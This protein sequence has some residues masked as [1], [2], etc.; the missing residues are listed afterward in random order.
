[1]SPC[2]VVEDWK[3]IMNLSFRITIC[4]FFVDECDHSSERLDWVSVTAQR[5]V[6]LCSEKERSL[7]WWP[8]LL[9]TDSEQMEDH[10]PSYLY[11]FL[12]NLPYR[13]RLGDGPINFNIFGWFELFFEVA[14]L[15]RLIHISRN[16][17]AS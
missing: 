6:Y 8:S 4:S 1:M 15:F 5:R 10:V 13:S 12:D 7:H 17:S 3:Y 2:W 9:N 11:I 14:H 16:L